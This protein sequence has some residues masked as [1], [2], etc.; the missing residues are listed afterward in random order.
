MRKAT[1]VKASCAV[2]TGFV[3]ILNMILDIPANVFASA[4]H[5]GGHNEETISGSSSAYPV[6][7]VE[8]AKS[9]DQ[10][11]QTIE[12]SGEIIPYQESDVFA[13]R[14]GIVQEL[15]VNTGDKVQKGQ[16]LGYLYADVEQT[17]LNAEL[18]LANAEKDAA[19]KRREFLK[20][21]PNQEGFI[22]ENPLSFAQK[23]I[24]LAQQI[25]EKTLSQ[26][27]TE[28]EVL[29]K[30]A[31]STKIQQEAKRAQIDVQIS[32]AKQRLKQAQLSAINGISDLISTTEN[33]LFTQSGCI[34]GQY[35]T[36]P[37]NL[38]RQA[39]S[40]RNY[41]S[42]YNLEGEVRSFYKDFLS[43]QE[44]GRGKQAD[45]LEK[46][47]DLLN[48]ALDIA[49][50]VKILS[51]KAASIGEAEGEI[52]E[53][54]ER[55]DE[56]T[57]HLV[58]LSNGIIDAL[59]EMKNA[60]AE[61]IRLQVDL[62]QETVRIAGEKQKLEQGKQKS[63]AEQNTLL[64]ERLSFANEAEQQFL[65][66]DLDLTVKNAQVQSIQQKIG[67]GRAIVAPFSGTI[68]RRYVNQGDS[69]N[70]ERP[71]YRI[72]NDEKKFIRFFVKES[73]LV[74]IEKNAEIIF[75][76]TSAASLQIL[77]QVTRIA[78]S[79]DQATRTV[80][81]EA[82]L[83]PSERNEKILAHMSVRVQIP[84]SNDA[85][86]SVIPEKALELSDGQ[87][88]WSVN[89]KVEIEKRPVS[90]RFIHDGYAYVEN[91]LDSAWIVTKSPVELREGLAV[92][93]TL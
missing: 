55:V 44:L 26:I 52:L 2:F 6:V 51:T 75:S 31:E 58:E 63:L 78:P 36:C 62:D 46:T 60:E 41:N 37:Q 17:I 53:L 65:E 34:T 59:S 70:F 57:D 93:T 76:P 1:F 49:K 89:Q 7:T 30:N 54:K 83:K 66:S 24:E 72:V 32:S 40:I 61:K 16:V 85:A 50:D 68:A 23:N 92:E 38:Y 48:R 33:L 67:A 64:T 35:I 18:T 74:F 20:G 29:T 90:V 77:A 80:L 12:A 56:N 82:D 81:I 47:D 39:V 10:L 13:L 86:L 87:S 91:D 9:A 8:K 45:D 42:A 25:K 15:S 43:F 27:D 5:D 79:L 11:N 21:Q 84:V 73:D 14:E 28:V 4:G 3:L 69:V 88:V 22:G 19:Q 71:V